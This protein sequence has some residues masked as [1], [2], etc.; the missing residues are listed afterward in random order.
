MV[1]LRWLMA[2]VFI[3]SVGFLVA[4]II[5]DIS[6]GRPVS[7]QPTTMVGPILLLLLVVFLWH[8]SRTG[9]K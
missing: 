3:V 2:I 5:E 4:S 6:A 7:A 1:I 8:Q 9:R